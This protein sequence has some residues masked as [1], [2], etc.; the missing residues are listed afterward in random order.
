MNDYAIREHKIAE[1]VSRTYFIRR[2][3]QT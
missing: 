2:K 1:I 3:I